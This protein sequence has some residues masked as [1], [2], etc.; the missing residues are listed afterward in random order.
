MW[1]VKQEI[2]FLNF[3]N[4][5]FN[6]PTWLVATGQRS[7]RTW[8]LVAIHGHCLGE[9]LWGMATDLGLCWSQVV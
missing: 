6:C 2:H 9:G 4:F 7:F 8:P 5:M 3:N 1:L